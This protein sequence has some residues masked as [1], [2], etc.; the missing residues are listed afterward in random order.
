M[1]K[2]IIILGFMGTGKTTCGKLLASKLNWKFVD[3]DEEIEKEKQLTINEIF[4]KTGE[5]GFRNIESEI[6]TRFSN[7]ENIVLSCGGGIV[8]DTENMEIIDK[9]G[10]QIL[11]TADY[12]TIIERLRNESNKRPLLLINPE[13]TIKALQNQR[14]KFYLKIKN[15]VKTENKTPEEIVNKII[16]IL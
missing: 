8:L 10:T 4:E 15:T 16:E 3:L 12:R 2:N 5:T 7:S 13:E 1:E 14:E 9:M 6:L 11:L